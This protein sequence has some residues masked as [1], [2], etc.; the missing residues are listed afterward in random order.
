[1][2]RG[3]WTRLAG[4]RLLVLWYNTPAPIHSSSE[5]HPEACR[6]RGQEAS[7]QVAVGSGTRAFSSPSRPR[8]PIRDMGGDAA[9]FSFCI[10][11]ALSATT[12]AGLKPGWAG[13]E[14]GRG[15]GAHS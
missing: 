3:F 4:M 10:C 13:G 9:V 1:M 14:V 12:K 5:V 2:H 15:S 6:A 8:F 11:W 7:S